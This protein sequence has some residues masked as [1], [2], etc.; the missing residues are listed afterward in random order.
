MKRFLLLIIVCFFYCSGFTQGAIVLSDKPFIINTLKDTAL[1]SWLHNQPAYSQLSQ[2]EKEAIYWI[3]RVRSHP[4]DFLNIILH[5]FLEQFP[6]AKSSYTRSLISELSVSKPLP[7]LAPSHK[8]Y[9]V[10]H[11]HAKDLGSNQMTIS[12]S[13]SKGK[14]FGERMNSFGYFECVSENVYEGKENGL[15]SVIFL[16]ID[17]GVKNLGHRKNILD[18]AMKSIGVSFYP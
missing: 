7:L 14:S 18:P 2:E 10:A 8:L 12:H 6:E 16:L 3:N 9:Q 13:S 4:K 15:L 11:A 1:E 17:N 5:P